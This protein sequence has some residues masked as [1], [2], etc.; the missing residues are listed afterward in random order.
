MISL[1][2]NRHTKK[3]L[4]VTKQFQF[5]KKHKIITY[6]NENSKNKFC[7]SLFCLQATAECNLNFIFLKYLKKQN[8]TKLNKRKADIF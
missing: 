6:N 8:L 3:A 5:E 7:Q 4:F 1:K 2:K